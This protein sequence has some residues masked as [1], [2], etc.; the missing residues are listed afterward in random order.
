M[1][2]KGYF[3]RSE[4]EKQKWVL[5]ML[6]LRLMPDTP[7]KIELDV[8]FKSGTFTQLGPYTSKKKAAEIFA[9]IQ[10]NVDRVQFRISSSMDFIEEEDPNDH[11][12]FPS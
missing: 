7:C 1:K 8:H 10:D 4:A 3:C 12:R 5:R 9:L 6:E 2:G 11:L